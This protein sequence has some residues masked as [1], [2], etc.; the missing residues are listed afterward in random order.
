MEIKRMK[1]QS[2]LKQFEIK[3]L[4]GDRNVRI[5][6]D[7][8]ETILIA[9]NGTGKTTLLGIV[10]AVLS[11]RLER[12]R[13]LD[14]SEITVSF[15]NKKIIHIPKASIQARINPRLQRLLG[16]QLKR[17]PPKLVEHLAGLATLLPFDEFRRQPVLAEFRRYA[18]SASTIP[19]SMLF[20]ILR[21]YGAQADLLTGLDSAH[22][23][24]IE[25]AVQNI[26]ENFPYQVLYF[27]TY[28]RIEEEI[29]N[30]GYSR[31]ETSDSEGLIH[32]GMNDVM[33]RIKTISDRIK[34][35]S[36]EWFSKINGQMLSQ[37][38]DGIVVETKDYARLA[39]KSALQLVLDRI[40]S[41]ISETHKSH[42]IDLVERQAITAP[43]HATLAYFLS[44]LI[45]VYDHQKS[46]DNAIKQFV[47]VCNGYLTDKEFRYNEGKVEILVYQKRNEK[48]IDL[49][50]L[51]SGEK[52][53]ISLFSRLY[54]E[55]MGDIA[56]LFDEP[57]LSLSVDWQRKLLPDVLRSG[58]CKFLLA[59]THSPFIFENELDVK[60]KD[61]TQF[62]TWVN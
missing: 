15:E 40:G 23:K 26:A 5:D 34:N 21:D 46:L 4:L 44:N 51:S 50:R 2:P 30:L 9:D 38:V 56:I 16:S 43:E 24:R 12:L 8:P 33:V 29:E 13:R 36:V 25:E 48:E 10:Y 57:E 60:A 31:S 32:F 27:P 11:G 39:D 35:L 6:F 59:T 7:D 42:I 61:L 62:I 20:E 22:P 18:G 47:S 37:L 49:S 52:Q 45:Q 3:G 28:R 1:N 55:D 17:V 14:F 54:L 19:P 41:S 53:I 58:R